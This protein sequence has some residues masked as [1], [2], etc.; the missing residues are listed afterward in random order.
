T[1]PLSGKTLATGRARAA[2]RILA[3]RGAGRSHGRGFDHEASTEGG[4]VSRVDGAAALAPGPGQPG[5][6]SHTARCGPA[7]PGW[8]GT[9]DSRPGCPTRPAQRAP[10]RPSIRTPPPALLM[11]TKT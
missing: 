3:H 6:L 8:V 4:V 7:A 9:R 5:R 11:L 1:V 10:L 2:I